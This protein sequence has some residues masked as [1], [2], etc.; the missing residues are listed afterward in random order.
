M[1]KGFEEFLLATILIIDEDVALLASLETLLE[2]E[3]YQ[4]FSAPHLVLAEQLLTT[5]QPALV[6]LEVEMAQGEGWKLLEQLAKQVLVLVLTT[7]GKEESVIHGLELG[8]VDYLTKPYRSIELLTRLRLRLRGRAPHSAALAPPPELAV[9]EAELVHAK[10]EEKPAFAFLLPPE[11]VKT[12]LAEIEGP[13][14]PTQLELTDSLPLP[15]EATEEA[16]PLPASEETLPLP[17]EAPLP[18]E[19]IEE[20]TPFP[21]SE[22]TLPL[23]SEAPPAP[24]DALPSAEGPEKPPLNPVVRWFT[25]NPLLA[26]TYNN[27]F[28]VTPSEKDSSQGLAEGQGMD[29]SGEGE[30]RPE[31][32]LVT[33]ALQTTL[34][35]NDQ[36][37]PSA[38]AS[39]MESQ[40]TRLLPSEP[41]YP[42]EADKPR[43]TPLNLF[44]GYEKPASILGEE[45]PPMPN[46]EAVP[47]LKTQSGPSVFM[48][49]A[50]EL[51][52]LRSQDA[53]TTADL[54]NSLSANMS[55]GQRLH[56][57]RRHRRI[58]LVQA[59]SD[60]KIRMWYLQGMEEEKFSLLPHSVVAAQMLRSYTIY[61]GLDVAQAMEE[62]QRNFY[63]PPIEPP[64]ALGYLSS[65]EQAPLPRWPIW[66]AAIL[67]ALFVGGTGIFFFDKGQLQTWG[68]SLLLRKA[69]ATATSTVTPKPKLTP[70]RR[71]TAKPSPT[72]TLSPSPT[73]TTT[74]ILTGSTIL[75]STVEL[76][77]P[78]SP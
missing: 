42:I 63:T 9:S 26:T 66:V 55:L 10:E 77:R 23:P 40:V 38:E 13:P 60:L 14:L 61:L 29:S 49:E 51:A 45:I 8:A 67:L 17:S 75:S 1:S 76:T 58:T 74:K 6:L 4:V 25:Q 24:N 47:P 30:G 56:A 64:P 46:S 36:P 48:D 32:P 22:E 72:P 33:Q 53:A 68:G 69:T 62:Y 65:S 78:L 3:G 18:V 71:P 35:S 54:P 2:Q 21:A 16:T 57:A 7:N 28:K 31:V 44:A 59:E 73:M 19:A 41:G 20:A 52:L 5:H 11:A 27:L 15:V 43:A 34:L 37:S 70:T 12:E 39:P 50:E